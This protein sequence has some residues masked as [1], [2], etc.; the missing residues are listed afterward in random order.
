ML[1]RYFL[2]SDAKIGSAFMACSAEKS[3]IY[4]QCNSNNCNGLNQHEFIHFFNS[5]RKSKVFSF[6]FIISTL[7]VKL[8]L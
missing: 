4:C 3:G 8:F 2:E 6:H 7:L 1:F 5:S